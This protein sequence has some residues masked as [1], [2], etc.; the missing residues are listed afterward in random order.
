MACRRVALALRREDVVQVER[1]E[2][3]ELHLS[4]V[5]RLQRHALRVRQP[6]QGVVRRAGQVQAAVRR[7][8]PACLRV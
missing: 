4:L 1:V 3:V 5:A 7:F 8:A 2:Q 6:V